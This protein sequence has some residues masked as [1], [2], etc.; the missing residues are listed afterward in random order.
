MTAAAASPE[1]PGVTICQVCGEV[2]RITSMAPDADGGMRCARPCKRNMGGRPPIGKPVLIRMPP[3]LRAAVE[4]RARPGESLA[5]TARRLLASALDP[6]AEARTA[7]HLNVPCP[8]CGAG[9]SE[10]C[11]TLGGKH[12]SPAKVHAERETAHGETTMARRGWRDQP[13]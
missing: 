11:K 4:A 3:E 1:P 13:G 12:L 9:F 10:P 7:L 5:A 8:H 6:L 2:R